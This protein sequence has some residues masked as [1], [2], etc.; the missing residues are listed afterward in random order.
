MKDFLLS[1]CL[2]PQIF[3]WEKKGEQQNCEK[4]NIIR[5]ICGVDNNM[6]LD[7][8]DHGSYMMKD[9]SYLRI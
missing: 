8:I 6:G 5:E 4:N 7:S 9:K 2:P 3:S 1:D